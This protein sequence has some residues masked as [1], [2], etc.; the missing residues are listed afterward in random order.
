MGGGG[1]VWVAGGAESVEGSEIA[2]AGG[3][4]MDIRR[5]VYL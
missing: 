1:E 2:D 4:V 3:A 5:T